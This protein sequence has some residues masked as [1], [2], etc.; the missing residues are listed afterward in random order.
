MQHTAFSSS[1]SQCL[2]SLE[3][4]PTI[5]LKDNLSNFNDAIVQTLGQHATPLLRTILLRMTKTL[6]GWTKNMSMPDH[7]VD[8]M[9]SWV[10]NLLITNSICLS[11]ES[12]TH[13][14]LLLSSLNSM[15]PTNKHSSELS[16]NSLITT[17]TISLYPHTTIHPFLLTLS[18]TTS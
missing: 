16:T 6:D 1:P 18:T 2:A 5:T 4:N 7:F 12:K 9:R 15:E 14:P 13:S 10:T 8:H 17:K 11:S 3:P